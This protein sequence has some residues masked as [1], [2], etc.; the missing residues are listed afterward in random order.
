MKRFIAGLIAGVVLGALVGTVASVRA[1]V[2]S[3]FVSVQNIYGRAT[4][5]QHGY[6]AGVYDATQA[7]A[8]IAARGPISSDALVSMARCLDRQGDTIDEFIA[9]ASKALQGASSSQAAAT[10]IMA[11][12]VQNP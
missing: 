1:D 2:G 12:C 6:V 9:Y 3:Y 8:V 10:P 7:L 11:A 4:E 5:F